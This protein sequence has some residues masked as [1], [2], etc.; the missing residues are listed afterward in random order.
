MK[1]ERD[2]ETEKETESETEIDAGRERQDG[3]MRKRG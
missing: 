2:R 3:R 1:R